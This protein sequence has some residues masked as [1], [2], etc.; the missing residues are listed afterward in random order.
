MITWGKCAPDIKGKDC[1][2]Q[3]ISVN[4][5]ITRLEH[6]KGVKDEGHKQ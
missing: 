4:R 5:E 2:H 6:P 1:C 3:K